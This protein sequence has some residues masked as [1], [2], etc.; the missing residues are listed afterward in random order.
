VALVF[1]AV[2][3]APA[4]DP[5]KIGVLGPAVRHLPQAGKDMLDGLKMGL[6]VSGDQVAGRKLELIEEDTEGNPATA[7][8]KYRKLVPPDKINVLE[9]ERR[10]LCGLQR[11]GRLARPTSRRSRQGSSGIARR[12]PALRPRRQRG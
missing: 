1:L 5:I 6:E 2:C 12:G 9:E 4:A 8:A 11:F 10:A 7:Q 3:P